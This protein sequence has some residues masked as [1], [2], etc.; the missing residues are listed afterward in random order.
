MKWPAANQAKSEFLSN[1]SH[2]L[3]TLLNSILG[4]ANILKRTKTKKDHPDYAGLDTMSA[5]EPLLLN[6]INDSLK[7]C[8]GLKPTNLNYTRAI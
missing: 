4:Y 6:L 2:E 7:T 5:A 8:R 1:M 3:R